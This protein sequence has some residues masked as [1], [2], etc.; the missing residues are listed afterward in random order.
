MGSSTLISWTDHTWNPWQ[1][2][3]KISEGCANCYMFEHRQSRFGVK[4]DIVTRSAP[5]TFNKPLSRQWKD[6]AKVFTCSWSD[7]FHPTADQWREEAWNIIRQT[8][9]LT[10]QI[11]TKRPERIKDNLPTDWGDGWDN[12]WLGTSVESQKYA[13]RIGFLIGIPA[14]V[15]FISA[16]PLI[17]SLVITPEWLKSIHWVIDGGESGPKAREA[18]VQWFRS[19]MCQCHDNGVAYWHKQNGGKYGDKGGCLLDGEIL[20]QFPDVK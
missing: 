20:Q 9:H 8:P 19:L 2:C 11:L 16:E 1:G 12:V 15:R 3:N 13:Y 14:K 17:G 6:P 5:A 18:D 4:S 10:Y 7:F